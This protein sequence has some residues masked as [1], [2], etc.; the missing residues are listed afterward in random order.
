VASDR[1]ERTY[2]LEPLDTS[3][4]F[5]GLGIVQCVLLGGGITL[6]VLAITAGV[7][8]LLAAVP[9]VGGGTEAVGLAMARRE[10]HVPALAA[11][12]EMARKLSV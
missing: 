6:A 1:V 5:L 12:I 10:L 2:R 9:I 7:P 11:L 3:G 8:V 4:V